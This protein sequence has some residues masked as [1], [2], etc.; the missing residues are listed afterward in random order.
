MI[1]FQTS[2]LR[3]RRSSRSC[4]RSLRRTTRFFGAR[5]GLPND[6]LVF[7]KH[8]FGVGAI[9][10]LKIR[11]SCLVQTFRCGSQ[12]HADVLRTLRH[13]RHTARALRDRFGH[14]HINVCNRRGPSLS[15]SKC[16]KYLA[17]FVCHDPAAP[18]RTA[19]PVRPCG[20]RPGGS[21]GGDRGIVSSCPPKQN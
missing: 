16:A 6:L 14:W 17:R 13:R 4:V 20:T 15:L 9:S 7:V 5:D 8:R 21:R 12:Y 10:Q 2:R 11:C 19:Y 3:M 1:S 18:I